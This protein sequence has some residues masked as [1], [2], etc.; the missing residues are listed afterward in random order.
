[1]ESFFAQLGRTVASTWQKHNFS[2]AGFPAIATAA[3]AARP[4]S[5]HVD[6]SLLVRDFL[7]NDDQPFQTS[8]GFAG[9]R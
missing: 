6:I 5:D 9:W 7:L 3:L 4:P 8:S 2:L 1:M